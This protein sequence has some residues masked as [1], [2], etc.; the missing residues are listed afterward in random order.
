M[1]ALEI[2]PLAH[3]IEAGDVEVISTT[4]YAVQVEEIREGRTVWVDWSTPHSRAKALDHYANIRKGVSPSTHKTG[5]VRVISRR[6][7]T[8]ATVMEGSKA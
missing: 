8:T 3:E 4:T 7:E 6:Q 2:N 1:S 5:R